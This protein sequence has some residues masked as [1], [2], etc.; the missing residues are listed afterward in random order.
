MSKLGWITLQSAIVAFWLWVDFDAAREAGVPPKPGIAFGVGLFFA[1]MV[2]AA[3]VV[4][5]DLI[6][7]FRR[8]HM[9]SLPTLSRDV[10]A[11]DA[12]GFA[13]HVDEAGQQGDRLLTSGRHR[14]ETPKL[15]P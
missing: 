5:R 4:G 10:D 12:I 8:T 9:A 13:G 1:F 7:R 2:T 15:L 14:G 11:R 3:L 6:Q